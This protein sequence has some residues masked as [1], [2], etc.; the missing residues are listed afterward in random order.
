M[1]L[2]NFVLNCSSSGRLSY[3]IK[4]SKNVVKVHMMLNKYERKSQLWQLYVAV[5]TCVDIVC[6]VS[7]HWCS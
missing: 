4:I 6:A 7:I 1:T 3:E 5:R 2:L